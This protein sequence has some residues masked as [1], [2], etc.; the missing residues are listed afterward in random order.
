VAQHF[1][2]E[3]CAK[4][5]R[6]AA[7]LT[8]SHT[9]SGRMRTRRLA[10]RNNAPVCLALGQASQ[11]RQPD[12]LGHRNAPP[13]VAFAVADQ[14]LLAFQVYIRE[15]QLT[16]LG[17]PEPAAI[18]QQQHQPI[19]PFPASAG[20]RGLDELPG[21]LDGQERRHLGCGSVSSVRPSSTF[22]SQRPLRQV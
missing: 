1:G 21:L 18:E 17:G 14:H 10:V 12:S 9:S 20:R 11:Q 6:R 7:A 19:S 3:G 8:T 5:A 4:P 22:R 2:R 15:V 13:P 16:E